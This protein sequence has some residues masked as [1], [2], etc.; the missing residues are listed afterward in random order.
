[1]SEWA[2]GEAERAKF[3]AEQGREEAWTSKEEAEEAAYTAGAAETAAAYKSQVPGLC[4]R[5]CS[6]T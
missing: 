4:R 1:M 6:E 2:K 3:E 5:Y